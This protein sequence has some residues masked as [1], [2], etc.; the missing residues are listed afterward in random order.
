MLATA[1]ATATA[2]AA[3]A[4]SGCGQGSIKSNVGPPQ[5]A[6]SAKPL[7]G[8]VVGIRRGSILPRHLVVIVGHLVQWKNFDP[9]GRQLVALAGARFHSKVIQTD[10]VFAWT[11]HHLGTIHYGDALHPGVTGTIVVTP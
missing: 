4:L 8:T 2:T 10:E 1:T 6:A 3:I 11:P 7:S 9:V 5:A